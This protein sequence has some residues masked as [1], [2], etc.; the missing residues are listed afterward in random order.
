MTDRRTIL[1]ST[2]L[3]ASAPAAS[4]T[5]L[6][7]PTS[8]GHADASV[9]SLREM[10]VEVGIARGYARV[11]VRQ[12]F[13]N[14][15]GEIQE[16]TWRFQLPPS[17]TVGDFA[18]WDGN[19]RIPG[20]ILEKKR[21]RAIYRE[22]TTRRIDPGLL[23]QGE[24]ED[25][26]EGGGGTRPSGG[27]AFSVKVAPIPAWGT[28]RLELQYQ[29]EVPWVDGTAEFRFPLKPGTGEAMT[30][31]TLDVRVV[32]EDGE[33][34]PA[35]SGALELS[36][37]EREP[38]EAL[39][40]GTAVKLG[41]DVVLRFR[42]SATSALTFTAFRNPGGVLPDGLALAPWER[43]S[44]VPPEKDGFFL[45]ELRPK[46]VG[47]AAST[48]EA[49]RPGVAVAFLFDTSLSHRWSGLE[50]AYALLVRQLD[51]LGPDDLFTVIPFD[52][53][54][55]DA[56]SLAAAT[57]EEKKKAL[58]HLRSRPLQPGTAVA[59]AV[60]AAA[61][62]L[63]GSAKPGR[64]VLLSDGAA[65]AAAL[66]ETRQ[67]LPLYAAM[68][69]EERPEGIAV[70]SEAFIH[71]ASSG[72]AE[73]TLF[74]RRFLA[75]IPPKTPA[76]GTDPGGAVVVSGGDPET[77]DVYPV[78]TQPPAPCSLSGWIGRYRKPATTADVSV[79]TASEPPLRTSFPEKALEARDL[80]RRWARARVDHL[81]RRIE[82][83]GE[84]RAFI[85]EILELSRRYKFV[86]PYTAFLAAPRSLLRPR[87]IQPGD[88]VIRVE[89]DPK[90][91]S[92]SALLPFGKRVE[93][94]RR[95]GTNLWE[96]RFLVP[97]A[98]PD[99]PLAVRLV[100]R[101]L[102]GET[103]VETKTLVVDGTAPTIRPDVPAAAAEGATI[104]IGAR[105]DADVVFLSVRLDDGPPVPLRWDQ[106]TL[107]S[108][109]RLTVPLGANGKR[110]LFYEAADAAGNR[111]FARATLEVR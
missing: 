13:E 50:A 5:G 87:R 76:K 45:L 36:R 93:L 24:E 74:L 69:G 64:I 71:L 111:G 85:D 63:K 110:D 29:H 105:T 97:D 38:R 28:K 108:T 62:R 102:S 101:D 41:R 72:E 32:V 48:P 54:P 57:A 17:G 22:L 10:S 96:G 42:P 7:V 34:A 4:Q 75:P 68:T 6:L 40:H 11:N 58:D 61:S 109:A 1:L 98:T 35:V 94:V 82:L 89:A 95:P 9:L 14:R 67:G 59:A 90:I 15:T 19:T 78:M 91:A 86:T 23:Q 60:R 47:S 31:G 30:A 103:V 56:S 44:E 33:M 107:R 3:L 52:R 53:T 55:A 26:A 66:E 83:E 8:I 81:L 65:P 43:P 21:A 2:L 46:A 99:G 51:L 104:T 73:E 92:A 37:A 18:V 79:R 100:L 39:Y 77:R 25:Q 49:K 80:P 84:K 70:A 27:A 88:P 106:A 16:G 12:V 20:V